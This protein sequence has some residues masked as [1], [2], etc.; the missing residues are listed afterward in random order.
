MN[1]TTLWRCWGSATRE[2]H[3][4]LNGNYNDKCH[5]VAFAIAVMAFNQNFM[6][7]FIFYALRMN[8]HVD[9]NNNKAINRNR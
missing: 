7:P 5:V 3:T 4:F 8:F 6:I 2:S 1:A 9:R